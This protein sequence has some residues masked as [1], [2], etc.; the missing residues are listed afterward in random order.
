M[1]NEWW[2]WEILGMMTSFLSWVALIIT[3]AVTNGE[4]QEKRFKVISFNTIVSL[5][6]TLTRVTVMVRV[7]SI[8]GQS[9]WLYFRAAPRSVSDMQLFDSASRGTLGSIEFLLRVRWQVATIG[10][11]LTILSLAVDPFAQQVVKIESRS[12]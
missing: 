8:I 5:M 12:L 7:S 4:P 10:A 6:V 3:L 9:K 11:A 1:S 2:L